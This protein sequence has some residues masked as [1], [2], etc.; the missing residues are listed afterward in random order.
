MR[1][2]L[3][4]HS[5]AVLFGAL[6]TIFLFWGE[7]PE[8]TES[9]EIQ[10]MEAQLQELRARL[11]S[12]EEIKQRF[13]ERIAKLLLEPG[14]V[15]K[16][17][18][19]EVHQQVTDERPAAGD[20]VNDTVQVSLALDDTV[21]L[22]NY[23][24]MATEVFGLIRSG[25]FDA[26]LD[27]IQY[28]ELLV[29]TDGE[30]SPI[31]AV[32][33][34]YREAAEYWAVYL[35][36]TLLTEPDMMLRFALDLRQRDRDGVEIGNI[37]QFLC[38]GDIAMLALSGAVPIDHTTG[39]AWVE[40]MRIQLRAGG[41]LRDSEIAGLCHI[42]GPGTVEVLGMAWDSQKNRDEV[43][44]ALVQVNSPESRRLLQALTFEIQDKRL[45]EAV[46]MWLRR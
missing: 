9:G 46:E 11:L 12:H 34:L 1:G 2:W 37:A 18:N 22:A 10:Q 13:D 20:V 23:R 32:G 17:E 16:P 15:I 7:Q 19:N 29:N 35:L 28:L 31:G 26:A 6:V 45:R 21:A 5:L 42:S 38:H 33:P 40:E 41:H 25:K 43:I 30:L 24:G 4:S 39:A 36:S 14:R 3:L 8:S 44:C 27:T